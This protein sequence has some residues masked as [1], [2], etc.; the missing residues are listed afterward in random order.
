MLIMLRAV[1]TW[2][3]QRLFLSGVQH[4]HPRL[5]KKCKT[6]RVVMMVVVL[7]VLFFV[8]Q[9]T[10]ETFLRKSFLFVCQFAFWVGTY[11]HCHVGAFLRTMFQG[12]RWKKMC[13]CLCQVLVLCFLPENCFDIQCP[14]L[15]FFQH[16]HQ[17]QPQPH[18]FLEVS[19][20]EK[21]PNPS[22]QLLSTLIAL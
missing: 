22:T 11:W 5:L 1:M 7:Q 19:L 9:L 12:D 13:S 21:V 6:L 8:I 2:A 3:P 18:K 15:T 20:H 17:Q 16:V 14:V 10:V 4:V